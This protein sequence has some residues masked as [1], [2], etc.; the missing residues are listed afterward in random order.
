VIQAKEGFAFGTHPMDEVFFADYWKALG[1]PF[2]TGAEAPQIFREDREIVRQGLE[3]GKKETRE[4]KA[5]MD[6]NTKRAAIGKSCR[7]R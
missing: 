6:H 7:D 5:A 1:R 3:L 2:P 4:F